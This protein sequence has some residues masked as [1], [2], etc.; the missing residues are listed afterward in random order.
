MGLMP[1]DSLLRVTRGVEL[2]LKQVSTNTEGKI[3]ETSMTKSCQ[4]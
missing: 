1:L 4:L 2:S 3:G